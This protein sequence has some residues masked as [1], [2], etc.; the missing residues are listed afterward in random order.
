M[1]KHSEKL[2]K[3][4]Y[5]IEENHV[6]TESES[7]YESEEDREI[8]HFGTNFIPSGSKRHVDTLDITSPAFKKKKM[9]SLS[10]TESQSTAA[11]NFKEYYS[12]TRIGNNL[13]SFS[14]HMNMFSMIHRRVSEL[15]KSNLTSVLMIFDKSG[16]EWIISNQMNSCI[17]SIKFPKQGGLTHYDITLKKDETPE[18][19]TCYYLCCDTKKLMTAL[20]PIKIENFEMI[21]FTMESEGKLTI[22]MQNDEK[23]KFVS[24]ITN[25]KISVALHAPEAANFS[26]MVVM[27]SSLFCKILQNLERHGSTIRIITDRKR[28]LFI[29]NGNG[30]MENET[31]RFLEADEEFQSNY[32][33]ILF[34]CNRTDDN[35]TMKIQKNNTLIESLNSKQHD[36]DFP[37]IY[38][39]CFYT[40]LLG[41]F[42]SKSSDVVY[43]SMDPELPITINLPILTETCICQECMENEP[44]P[45]HHIVSQITIAIKSTVQEKF[46]EYELE[47]IKKCG[48]DMNEIE[49]YIENIKQKDDFQDD[50]DFHQEAVNE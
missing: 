34:R 16:L 38:I 42:R 41:Q 18:K 7:E 27:N 3:M 4:E 31:Y 14:I 9:E 20:N 5:E 32:G 8:N 24:T 46:P 39:D 49:K 45:K 30:N 26:N 33:N 6:L 47:I 15:T 37:K 48:F 25:Q 22:T 2:S 12:K 11:K 17:A 1:K 50:D 29:P 21:N 13:V 35:T 23:D 44:N 10:K 40:K 19:P 36:K 28:L 43:I